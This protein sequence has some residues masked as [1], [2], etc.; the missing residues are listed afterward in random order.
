[1]LKISALTAYSSIIALALITS[2]AQAKDIPIVRKITFLLPLKEFSTIEFPF[3]IKSHDFTPFVSLSSASA[4]KDGL[5]DNHSSSESQD[6]ALPS[7]DD[8]KNPMQATPN[9]LKQTSSTPPLPPMNGNKK[10]IE[11]QKGGNFFKFY[12]R[13]VGET[14]L[15]VF[16]YEKYPIIINLSVVENKDDVQDSVYKFVDYEAKKDVAQKFESTNH[17]KVVVGITKSLYNNE[18]PKG[19][20]V[21]SKQGEFTSQGLHFRLIKEFQGKN[22]SGVEYIMQNTTKD[23]IN[24][25]AG[26]FKGQKGIYGITFVHDILEPGR[27]TR[28]FIVKQRGADD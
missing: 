15:I 13:K 14:Q 19:Y 28:L 20:E 24:T 5:T 21:I 25:D 10:P 27:S 23:T 26:I 12:P 8:K 16:G 9:G 4:N 7:L 18:P 17:D 2:Q 6:Y 3:E 22:Y 11:W 1:M